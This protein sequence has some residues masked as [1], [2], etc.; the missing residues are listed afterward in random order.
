VHRQEVRRV[1]QVGD[2]PQFLF[3]RVSHLVRDAVRIA[4]RGTFPGLQ[5]QVL[6][7]RKSFRHRLARIFIA[8][9]VEREAARIGQPR[10]ILQRLRPA[11]EQALHLLRR[12]QVALGIGQQAEAGFLD[13]HMLADAGHHIL[14]RPPLGHMIEHVVGGDEGQAMLRS[15]LGKPADAARIIAAVEMAGCQM[16]IPAEINA[17]PF[18]EFGKAFIDLLRRQRHQL[19]SEAMIQHVGIGQRAL[20][21]FRAPLA[22]GEQRAEP[23]IG[24]AVL[25]IAEQARRVLEIEPAADDE[26]NRPE[27]LLE[28]IA[29]VIGPHNARQRVAVRDPDRFIPELSRLQR[30]LLRTRPTLQ[31]G[32]VGGNL[33]LDGTEGHVT[34]TSHA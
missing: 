34:R 28:L 3:E 12:F 9:L 16:S 22:E 26:P 32:E 15:Q 31:E 13:G 5:L 7:R 33:K 30:Q 17:E 29:S 23:A 27:T 4:L 2:Q 1:V 18:Q 20:A 11:L 19:L 25:R 10:G 24:R 14:Q 6:L 21:F 8:Q